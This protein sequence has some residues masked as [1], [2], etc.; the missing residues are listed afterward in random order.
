MQDNVIS[1]INRDNFLIIN[2]IRFS[3][4]KVGIKNDKSKKDIKSH[5]EISYIP[6]S[7]CVKLFSASLSAFRV[8]KIYLCEYL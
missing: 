1:S 5:T 4:T 7:I 2:N 3:F 6:V 8:R